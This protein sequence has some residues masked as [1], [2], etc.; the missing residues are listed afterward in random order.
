[1]EMKVEGSTCSMRDLFLIRITVLYCV[2]SDL[3]IAVKIKVFPPPDEVRGG[4]FA[5][6]VPVAHF[7]TPLCSAMDKF[8]A[9]S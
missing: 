5:R 8:A 4:G 6:V 7:I 2:R 3:R 1:M 9:S